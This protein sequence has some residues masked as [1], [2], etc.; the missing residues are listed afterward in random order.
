MLKTGLPTES[1]MHL[2]IQLDQGCDEYMGCRN[3]KTPAKVVM[4]V[5]WVKVYQ[6]P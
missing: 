5:D 2:G 3:S 1:V 6:A 4:D